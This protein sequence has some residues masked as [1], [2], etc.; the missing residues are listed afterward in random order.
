MG[1][2]KPATTPWF[3]QNQRPHP[4]SSK[5]SHHAQVTRDRKIPKFLLH[6]G[7]SHA[8]DST[9]DVPRSNFHV[10]LHFW[11]GGMHVALEIRPRP[12][13]F[14]LSRGE[15]VSRNPILSYCRKQKA[16]EASLGRPSAFRRANPDPTLSSA[17]PN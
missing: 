8:P 6:G 14:G 13:P 12:V 2:K 16:R 15:E 17:S 1:H 10:L 11:P 5:S 4:G 9:F 7:E 3:P